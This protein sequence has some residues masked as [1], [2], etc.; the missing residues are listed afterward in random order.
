MKA[1][2]IG[3]VRLPARP[4]SGMGLLGWCNDVNNA[5][6]QLRDRMVDIKGFR[7]FLYGTLP[8]QVTITSSSLIAKAG[9][10]CDESFADTIET[11]PANGVWYF[12][13]LLVIDDTTGDKVSAAV[14]WTQTEGTDSSTDFYTTIAQIT[15]VDTV[16]DLTSLSQ[17]QY[18]TIV[19]IIHGGNSDVWDVDFF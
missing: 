7:P 18:G 6:Q 11:A 4:T 3:T 10:F 12:Q 2:Q 13:G 5:L 15:V 9:I 1:R 19:G 14:E 17:Y 8:F 16:P